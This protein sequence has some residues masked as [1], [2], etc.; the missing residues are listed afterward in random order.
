VATKTVLTIDDS[1]RLP[2]EI[3]EGHELVDGELVETPVDPRWATDKA[4]LNNMSLRVQRFVPDLAIEIVT[5]N[6]SFESLVRKKDRYRKC[7]TREVWIRRI[8]S[9][10]SFL[11]R[12]E[13]AS[14]G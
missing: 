8:R 9:R 14:C 12:E 7:G 3:A 4:L 13:T 11:P 10:F 2:Q 5:P 1:G 6:D